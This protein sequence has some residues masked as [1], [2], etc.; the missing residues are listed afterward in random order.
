MTDTAP[1]LPQLGTTLFS[2]TLEQRAPGNDLAALLRKVA[3]RELGPGVE[4]VAFQS[5]RG[6]PRLDDAAVR[7]VRG[8]IADS[9]LTPSCLAI[10]L[11]LALQPG[12][13]LSDDE[14][15]EYVAV[16]LRGAASLGFPAVRVGVECGPE[17]MTRLLP[18]AEQLGVKIGVEIHAPLTI[19][20]PPVAALKELFT[21][22]DTEWLGF[23]PDFSASMRAVPAAVDDAHRKAGI[24]PELTALTR[25][26]WAQPGPTM[27]KFPQLEQRAAELGAGQAEIGNLKMIFTMHGRMEPERWADFFPHVIHVHGKF[28]GVFDGPDGPSDPSI[29]YPAIVRVL[30]EQGYTGFISSEYEAHAYTGLYSAFDQVRAQH[31]MLK[32][33]LEAEPAVAR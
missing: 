33:L 17:I 29:D 25:Q 4:M 20:A 14:A 26:L 16:Q 8:L 19:D 9:G 21:R 1:G 28:Y 3:T 10:N 2:L 6:W 31:D 12:R 27:A 24:A 30:R 32:R 23:I 13:L 22:L 7:K 11:D 5:L 18:L 15:Y